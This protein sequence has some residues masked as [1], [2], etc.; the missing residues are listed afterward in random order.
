M[1]AKLK[2][3]SFYISRKKLKALMGLRQWLFQTLYI[4]HSIAFTWYLDPNRM[5]I[6]YP[7][8]NLVKFGLKSKYYMARFHSFE[9]HQTEYHLECHCL[10][11]LMAIKCDVQFDIDVLNSKFSNI[12]LTLKIV[13]LITLWLGTRFFFKFL[14]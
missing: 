13:H 11:Y 1:G 8:L 3:K 10:W 7:I 12:Y 4:C 5:L 2:F 9:I 6:S 14:K